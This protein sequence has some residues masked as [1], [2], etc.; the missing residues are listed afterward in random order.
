MSSGLHSRD[1]PDNWQI[2][3]GGLP[4]QANEAEIREVF[5]KY[6]S[7]SEIRVNPKNFA[8]VV[9]NGPE[10]VEKIMQLK[11]T[12]EI[13][14]KP[15]NIEPKRASNRGAGGFRVGDRN[16]TFGGS[17]GGMGGKGRGGGGGGGKGS[18]R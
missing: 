16:K 1:A 5:G 14:G 15:L 13:R 12:F 7:I 18:K 10:P 3:V 4:P 17:G 2:F 9:F 6:D 11:E 8:F